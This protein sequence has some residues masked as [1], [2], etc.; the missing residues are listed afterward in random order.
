MLFIKTSTT[1]DFTAAALMIILVIKAP[2]I[3]LLETEF[4]GFLEDLAYLS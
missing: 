1:F 2:F 3:K 4:L